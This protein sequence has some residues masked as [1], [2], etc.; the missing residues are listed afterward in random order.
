M[1]TEMPSIGQL[2][3]IIGSVA[4]RKRRAARRIIFSYIYLAL[5]GAFKS[6]PQRKTKLKKKEEKITVQGIIV[7]L[8]W[9]SPYFFRP[10]RS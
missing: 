2:S 4:N 8:A 9:G 6:P 10:A 7:L 3:R 1:L 5:R